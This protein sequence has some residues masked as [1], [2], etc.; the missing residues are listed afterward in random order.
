MIGRQ[1]KICTGFT[2]S[3]QILRRKKKL[4]KFT[5]QW[6]L[7]TQNN[8]RF[9]SWDYIH[10]WRIRYYNSDGRAEFPHAMGRCHES[11]I[12]KKSCAYLFFSDEGIDH[13]QKRD[14]GW[15]WTN[16]DNDEWKYKLLSV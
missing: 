16:K 3:I 4:R 6:R 7:N 2:Q 14:I 10:I 8:K 5:V 12:N 9:S 13:S 11:D 1:V 15:I